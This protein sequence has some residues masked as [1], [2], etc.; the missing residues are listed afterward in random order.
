M[1]IGFLVWNTFQVGH[2]AE[3]LRYFDE[4]EIIFCDRSPAGLKKFDPQWLSKYGAYSRFVE[5]TKL[6]ALDGEYDAI[7]TQFT[8]PLEK[9]WV[10]T[11]LVMCQYSMAK[12]KTAFNARWLAADLGLVYGQL[13]AD[14]IGQLCPI[15]QAG[16]WRFDPYFSGQLD[17][18]FLAQMRARLDNSKPTIL[19]MPTWGDLSSQKMFRT[20]MRPLLPEFNVVYKPHH[21]TPLRDGD[22]AGSLGQGTIDSNIFTGVLDVGPYLMQLADVVVSDMSGAIFDSLYC[23]KPTVLLSLGKDLADHRKADPSA[24]E[25]TRQPEIGPLV[26]LP[27]DLHGAVHM[28]LDPHHPYKEK[29][30]ALV[31][32][33]FVQRGGCAELASD[34]IKQLLRGELVRPSLQT[35]IAPQVVVPLLNRTYSNAV[36]RAKTQQVQWRYGKSTRS[37]NVRS[38][39]KKAVSYMPASLLIRLA[40]VAQKLGVNR[41]ERFLY[42]RAL[43]A[44][45]RARA[46]YWLAQFERARGR[47]DKS[48]ALLKLASSR[49]VNAERKRITR[50]QDNEEFVELGLALEKWARSRPKQR[51]RGLYHY[52]CAA[53]NVR[54]SRRIWREAISGLTEYIDDE[55]NERSYIRRLTYRDLGLTALASGVERSNTDPEEQKLD[56]VIALLG[57]MMTY[58]EK[59]AQND[60]IPLPNQWVQTPDGRWEKLGGCECRIFEMCIILGFGRLA[61][62]DSDE[63][64]D[65]MIAVTRNFIVALRSAGWAI[66]PRMQAGYRG[67]VPVTGR[68]PCA[69]WHTTHTGVPGQIHLKVGSYNGHI[70]ID[71]RGYSGWSSMASRG[72]AQII[73]GVDL[74]EATKQAKHLHDKIVA[75]GRS[76]YKQSEEKV[77]DVGPYVFLPMQ[78]L[79]DTVARLAYIDCLTL[80]RKLAAW[81]VDSSY[82]VVVKRHP[83]CTIKS[84]AK[85]IDKE[86][87]A[88]RI[89]VSNASIHDLI[90][91]ATCIVTVNSGVGA[92]ALMH[93][94]PV[95]TT[96]ESDYSAATRLVKSVEELSAALQTLGEEYIPKDSMLK[97]LW[98]FTKRYQVHYSDAEATQ[99][100]VLDLLR[101]LDPALGRNHI[102]KDAFVTQV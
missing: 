40:G 91:G 95:I 29:N 71:D 47:K 90:S 48:D 20:A 98:F 41:A 89:V 79:N 77:P 28:M 5:Q 81:G 88:G 27:E 66:L 49:N 44:G 70:I 75:S 11:R 31:T 67:G 14:I 18:R 94:K 80:L 2:F 45:D 99:A 84:V 65:A 39:V 73:E 78:V 17:E 93:Y 50:L 22:K 25:I 26:D 96:G 68:F 9:P 101:T 85:A 16:N 56:A 86:C 12:P 53:T 33:S 57:D 36:R 83:K 63:V 62:K 97:F 4:P 92:E 6:A 34:G 52:Y 30:S 46:P 59:A 58:L 76:K 64:R 32:E 13:S 7:L 23:G 51:R 54:Y 100:R 55:S 8:P 72:L 60:R 102:L 15:V 69:T 61:Q 43:D 82:T 19:F 10:K 35:Y 42:L 37:L 38:L 74:K 24:F 1:R 87:S 3:L 21:M